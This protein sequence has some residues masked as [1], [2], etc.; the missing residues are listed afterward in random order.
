MDISENLGSKTCSRRMFLVA[1]ATSFAGLLAACG[2]KEQ[3]ASTD[4]KDVPL[5]SAII[6]GDFIFAQPESGVYKAYSTTCPHQGNKIT[7][8][9]GGHVICTKHDSVFNISDGSVVSGQART[10]LTKASLSN[11]GTTLTAT[12]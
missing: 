11:E 8:V 7:K 1:T 9:D 12:S 4:A 5:G 10:G 6:V 3:S 2:S